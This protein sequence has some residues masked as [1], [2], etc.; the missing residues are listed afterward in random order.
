METSAASPARVDWKTLFATALAGGALAAV[1]NLLLYFVARAAGVPF[2]GRFGGPEA[3]IG[4]LVVPMVAVASLLPA[5]LAAAIYG[6]LVRSTRRPR[7]IF[8]ALT[9]LFCLLSCGGPMNIGDATPATK[10]VLAL[11]HFVAAASISGALVR[12]R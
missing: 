2:E 4:H 10:L 12:R 3:P 1:L 7:V 11:M 8:L 9:V 6:L 5:P